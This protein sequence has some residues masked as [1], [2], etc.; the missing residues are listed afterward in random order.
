[1]VEEVEGLRGMLEYNTDLFDATTIERMAGHFHTLLEGI[2]TNLEQ[3]IGTLPLLTEPERHQLLVAWN[4]TQTEYPRDLCVHQRF[5]AQAARTPDRVAVV[6]EG[7]RLTYRELNQRANQ[8]AHHL[9]SLGVGPDVLVGIYVERSLE[10]V[11]GILGI[12]KAGGAYLPLDPAYPKE[13]LAFM[14]EDTQAPVLLTQ[15]RLLGELPE[16]RAAVVCLDADREVTAQQ[17]VENPSSGVTSGHLAYVIYTSGSTGRP[18]GVKIEHRSV[19]NTLEAMHRESGL[20]DADTLLS[21]TTLSFD[22]SVPELFLPL[23]VGARVVIV[24]RTVAADG[25]QL[26]RALVETGSTVMQGTPASWTLLL[27]AGW[28]GSDRLRALCGGEALPQGLAAQLVERMRSLWNLYGPTETTVWST[29]YRVSSVDGPISIGRPIANTQIYLLDDHGRPAPIGVPGELYIGG[30]G[31]AQGYLNRPGLTAEKF[32][33]DPFGEQP[34]ARLYKTGD[35]AR[36]LPDGNIQFLGRLDHQVKIRGFR[37][38]LGEIEAML[39]QHPAMRETV[40]LARED[41]PGDKR[42]VAYIVPDQEP[43][44]TMEE[45]QGYLRAKLPEYM[46]PSAFVFLDGM[47]LMPNGK[48]DRQALPAPE[49]K[50]P[51]LESAFAPPRTPTEEL[52]AGV[53]TQVLGI[54]QVGI[55]DNFFELGGH[56][57]L[58]TRVVSRVRDAFQMELPLRCIFEAPTVAELSRVIKEVSAGHAEP[59]A[60]R[61]VPVERR[62]HRGKRS[63]TGMLIQ[64][65]K[66]S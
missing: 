61:I 21:M 65:E 3:R 35:L 31:V 57:L 63:S 64:V 25:E 12:L 43:V 23:V 44:P 10:M 17:S 37:I 29:V 66:D 53:W 5:E 13:R 24:S 27:S 47:P 4:A 52:L 8:L 11:V 20:T 41:E 22:I 59:R 39:G 45:L 36:Y 30:D 18:K 34:G 42:L 51:E 40:V 48:V 26:A 56:S 15:E 2:V 28:E 6:F 33:P 50:R 58:A 46:V 9:Q 19:V 55:Y 16:H 60:P 38:E 7:Q 54:E 32:I 62:A 14:L 1:M 49:R